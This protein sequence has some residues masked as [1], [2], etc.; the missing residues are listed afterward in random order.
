VTKDHEK[1][2][3]DLS[4]DVGERAGRLGHEVRLSQTLVK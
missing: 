4:K 2:N 3:I 1:I